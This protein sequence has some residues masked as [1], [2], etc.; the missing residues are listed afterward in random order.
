MT[1]VFSSVIFSFIRLTIVSLMGCEIYA[2][3]KRERVKEKFYLAGAFLALAI[4]E[5]LTVF[6]FSQGFLPAIS[7]VWETFCIILLGY[8]FLYPLIKDKQKSKKILSL[9]RKRLLIIAFSILLVAGL[10]PTPI[11]GF[12]LLI[13]YLSLVLEKNT[14]F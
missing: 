4:W 10:L 11:K 13:F 1:V 5:L 6:L 8:A 9:I 14:H 7:M 12:F 2:E 3:W